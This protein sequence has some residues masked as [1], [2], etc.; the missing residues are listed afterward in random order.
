MVCPHCSRLLRLP[1]SLSLSL[2]RRHVSIGGEEFGG[3]GD[4]PSPLL[5]FIRKGEEALS[6]YFTSVDRH[7]L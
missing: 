2:S 4:W 3:V 1:L 7:R 6:F 5:L